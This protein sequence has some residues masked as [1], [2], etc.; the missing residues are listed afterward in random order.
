MGL[1]ELALRTPFMLFRIGI[2]GGVF[3]H[4]N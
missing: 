1:K 4:R 3:E 2:S